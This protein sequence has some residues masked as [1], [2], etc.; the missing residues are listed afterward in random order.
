MSPTRHEE[1]FG[2]IRMA[3]HTSPLAISAYIEHELGHQVIDPNGRAYNSASFLVE[4]Q[5][6]MQHWAD[7]RQV[8]IRRG[9]LITKA[10]SA[11]WPQNDPGRRL[12]QLAESLLTALNRVRKHSM[13]VEVASEY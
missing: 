13:R 8:E 10:D 12:P 1:M 4:R 11:D 2:P 5:L 6:M 9:N 7:S 3:T